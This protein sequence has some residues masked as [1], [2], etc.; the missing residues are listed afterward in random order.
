[1]RAAAVL[2]LLVALLVAHPVRAQRRETTP[3]RPVTV[4]ERSG[5][6]ATATAADL[7]AFFAALAENAPPGRLEIGTFGKS[8]AGRDL[9]VVRVPP[10]RET[11]DAD[12][13]LRV[14]VVAN[15]HA[16]EVCGKEAVQILLREIAYGEHADITTACELRFVPNYNVDGNEAVDPK[17]RSGQ[18]G[19]VAGMGRRENERGLDLNRDCVKAESAEFRALLSLLRDFDPHVVFD[20]HT[21][22]GS[23]HGY[24]VTYATS[25]CTNVDD[26]LDHYARSELIPAARARLLER[27]GFRSFDYGNLE[28]RGTPAWASFDHTPRYLTNYVGLRNRISVLSEAYAYDPFEVRVR[29]TRAFVLETLHTLVADRLELIALCAAADRRGQEGR[30][31]PGFRWDT[32]LAE[33]EPGEVLMGTWDQVPGEGGS[34]RLVRRTEFERRAMT[35]RTRFVSRASRPLPAGGWAIEAPSAAVVA[36]LRAHGIEFRELAQ[37][38]TGELRAFVPSSG[39]RAARP[40]QG[41]RTLK[42]RGDWQDASRTLPAGT[43]IVPSH[44]AL[45]RLAAQLLE[46]ESED[47]LATWEFFADQTR[48]AREGEAGAHPVFHLARLDG[49]PLR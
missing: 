15:I 1:M 22:N 12:P 24:H 42:L 18:N 17:N 38:W 25:L 23:P 27:H 33:G 41:H 14:L 20:L 32:V 48:I 44:Q 30:I 37:P 39:D 6:V 2:A 31:E 43:V 3:P 45:A 26:S 36:N 5:F 21:T 8:E 7:D 4:A 46:P 19:P 11:A 10:S 35:I 49:L 16:G 47:G 9:V 40:F 34:T 28:G 13:P 29:S